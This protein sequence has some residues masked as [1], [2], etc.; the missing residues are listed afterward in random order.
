V[1]L[2]SFGGL[3]LRL[4][5]PMKEQTK[6]EALTPPSVHKMRA[7]ALL[8][9]QLARRIETRV[10]GLGF[11]RMK[12]RKRDEEET[13]TE[14]HTPHVE[15]QNQPRCTLENFTILAAPFTPPYMCAQAYQVLDTPITPARPPPIRSYT[16]GHRRFEGPGI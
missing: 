7:Q 12:M 16:K 3:T 8:H 6:A 11:R 9:K 5:H 13:G 4:G 15:S 14:K 1:G 10:R 2:R